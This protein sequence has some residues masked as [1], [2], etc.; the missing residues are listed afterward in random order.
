MN[1]PTDNVAQLHLTI[2]AFIP[3]VISNH[4]YSD[5]NQ[6]CWFIH[7][8]SSSSSDQFTPKSCLFLPHNDLNYIMSW[9]RPL[10][11]NQPRCIQSI[12]LDEHESALLISFHQV[13]SSSSET[14]VAD[15]VDQLTFIFHELTSNSIPIW[16]TAVS[17]SSNDTFIADVVGHAPHNDISILFTS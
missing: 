6:P 16:I 7:H 15:V 12:S 10:D 3:Q 4:F 13:S 11:M 9:Y 2:S 5:T 14:F 1:R 8:S 17:S